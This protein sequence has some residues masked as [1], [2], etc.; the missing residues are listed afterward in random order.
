MNNIKILGGGIAGLTAAINLKR[1]SFTVE[2]LDYSQLLSW[3][4]LKPINVSVVNRFLFERLIN[5]LNSRNP[6]VRSL[7]GGNDVNHILKRLYSRSLS[8]FLRF[9]L[10]R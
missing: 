9:L 5:V 7:L 1:A 2:G 6:I 8:H 10:F 4:I 3:E